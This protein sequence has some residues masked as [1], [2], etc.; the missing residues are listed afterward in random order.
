MT[1][2]D[3]AHS[4]GEQYGDSD[5]SRRIL[6]ALSA[7]G[8]DPQRL[9]RDDLTGFDEFHGGGRAS[10]RALARLAAVG[11]GDRVLDVGCGIGGPARTLADELDCQVQGIDLTAT[12]IDAARMLTARLGMQAQCE[13]QVA[14][15]TLLPFADATFDLV[16]SQ[17]VIMNVSDKSL[18]LR[19]MAR[20]LR[21]GG[22]VALE[23]AAGVAGAE[24]VYPTF[25]SDDGE[26]SHLVTREEAEALLGGAGF[27]VH[28]VQDLTEQA[29]AMAEKRSRASVSATPDP[30]GMQVLV[31]RHLKEK[32][33]NG[34]RNYREG[35]IRS[36]QIVAVLA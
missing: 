15:A 6:Q 21:P 18:C 36:L 24:P 10:T 17:N 33:A 16:W 34:L 22:R 32:F 12:F 27:D 31:R 30:L 9:R 2:A 29:V 20:V 1:Q 8:R 7:A 13:F 19:E 28:T 14:S 3:A 35:R 11:K 23:F 25:W 4:L 5:L 26:H